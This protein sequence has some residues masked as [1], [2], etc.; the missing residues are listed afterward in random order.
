[1]LLL[2]DAKHDRTPFSVAKSNRVMWF[3]HSILILGSPIQIST[4]NKKTRLKFS[5]IKTTLYH[6]DEHGQCNIPILPATIKERRVG[7]GR[8]ISLLKGYNEPTIFSKSTK[9]VVRVQGVWH[10]LIMLST[11]VNSQ[12]F[13]IIPWL[14]QSTIAP[15]FLWQSLTV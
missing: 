5:F 3:Q 4:N 1:M 13:C 11:M 10:S 12:A 7:S 9:E 6:T 8:K 15:L 14:M 2:I